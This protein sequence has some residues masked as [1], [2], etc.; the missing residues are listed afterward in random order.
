ME[1][2]RELVKRTEAI[3]MQRVREIGNLTYHATYEEMQEAIHQELT[4]ALGISQSPATQVTARVTEVIAPTH[5]PVKLRPQRGYRLQI[6]AWMKDHDISSVKVAANRLAVSE[7]VLKSIMTTKGKIRHSYE[8]LQ[9][10]L[11]AIGVVTG[12]QSG[13]QP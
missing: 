12:D 8:T 2:I 11:K 6:R 1:W 7:S 9:K 4:R 10:V 3:V 13:D 5:F